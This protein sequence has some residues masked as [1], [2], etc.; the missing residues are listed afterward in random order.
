MTP[1]DKR[2]DPRLRAALD[3]FLEFRVADI[4]IWRRAGQM[5]DLTTNAMMVLAVVLRS[6]Y[7]GEAVRQVD[8][9]TALHLSAAGASTIIDVLEERGLVKREPFEGDRRALRIV[10]TIEGHA[11]E[12]IV[13]EADDYLLDLLAEMQPDEVAAVVRVFDAMRVYGASQFP[14]DG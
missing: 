6:H 7:R 9:R 8:I 1:S 12:Q 2:N 11:V 10:P 14:V 3:A 5:L 13:A 4:D